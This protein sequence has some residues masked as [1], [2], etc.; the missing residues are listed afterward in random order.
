MIIGVDIDGVLT[1][2]TEGHNYK[3]RTPNWP[4]IRWVNKKHFLE[5]HRIILFS[6]RFEEDR[7]VTEEWL[8]EYSVYHDQLILGKPKF[9]LYIDD[10][11]KRP[12]EVLGV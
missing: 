11:A 9:D 6:S 7:A 3:K 5:Q 2:E 1:I 8:Q 10:I 4:M 12:E